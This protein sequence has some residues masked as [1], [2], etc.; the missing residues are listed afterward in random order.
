MCMITDFNLYESN[1]DIENMILYNHY[2]A[3]KKIDLSSVTRDFID[4]ELVSVEMIDF[5]MKNGANLTK[6]TTYGFNFFLISIINRRFDIIKLLVE[7]YDED[8]NVRDE[9]GRNAL[10]LLFKGKK[11]NTFEIMKWLLEKT[12]INI[13]ETNDF[14]DT[15]LIYYSYTSQLNKQDKYKFIKLLIKN[16]ADWFILAD[17]LDFIKFL[18]EDDNIDIIESIKKDFPKKWKN[19]EKHEKRKNFN[20]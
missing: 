13:N 12:D 9:D 14:G 5:L 4:L 1:R 15:P 6:Q 3:L 8:V 11:D 7:K 19:Y 20:L 18:K 16:D 10:H 17:G 2:D